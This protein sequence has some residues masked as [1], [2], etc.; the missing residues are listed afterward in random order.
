MT[1]EVASRS[2]SLRGRVRHVWNHPARH[3]AQNVAMRFAPLR[4]MARR[5]HQTGAMDDPDIVVDRAVRVV[6]GADIGGMS[7]RDARLV[8]IGPGH[9]LGLAV[10]LLLAGA[11]RV[12]AIDTVRYA[13]ATPDPR[14]FIEL[15]R[16]CSEAGLVDASNA[17][18]PTAAQ[19]ASVARLGYR[20]VDGG[21]KWPFPDGSKDI[22]YSFS[23]LEH[24]RDL[25]GVLEESRRVLR[26]GGLSIHTID[27]R[28]HYNLGPTE[29]WLAF[30]AFE[31]RQWDRMTS[32]RFAWC[33][34][35]RAPELRTLFTELFELVQFT[36]QIAELPQDFDRRRLASRFRRFDVDELSVSFVSVVARKRD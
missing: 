10:S 23:V 11:S 15:W 27:L 14:S 5:F 35:L 28:D 24:V 34:R 18:D 16:R 21:G 29:D 4:W 6:E 1:R 33:N 13:A 12:E 26:A 30:L 19:A 20:I 31:D 36:E 25:R 9:T 7:V 3:V 8:E 17:A 22:V 32:A 2:S